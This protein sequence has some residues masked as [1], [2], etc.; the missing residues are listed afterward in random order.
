MSTVEKLLNEA[1]KL[2]LGD[3]KRLSELLAE[4]TR[5]AEQSEREKAIRS[6]KGSMAGL[7]PSTEDFLA[8]KY[9]EIDR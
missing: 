5:A 8:E 6:A 2:P 3:R 1:R 4:E 9:A 7:L